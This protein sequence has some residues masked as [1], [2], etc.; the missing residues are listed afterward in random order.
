MHIWTCVP[1]CVCVC[2]CECV[3][4][5]MCSWRSVTIQ[6]A[7][8]RIVHQLLK[9]LWFSHTVEHIL[10]MVNSQLL[11]HRTRQKTQK[12][13]KWKKPCTESTLQRFES[14]KTENYSV[15]WLVSIYWTAK[16]NGRHL[17]GGANTSWGEKC[18]CHST[19]EAITQLLPTLT[20]FYA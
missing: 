10:V 7:N 15:L 17:P 20:K 18:I 1:L 4:G 14:L 9:K 3:W 13:T 5:G 11:I 6:S 19:V 12:H 2:V 8:N 16:Q